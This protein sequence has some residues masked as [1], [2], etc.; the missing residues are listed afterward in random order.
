[1]VGHG[2]YNPALLHAID[3][4]MR[5]FEKDRPQ[6]VGALRD[7]VVR[8]IEAPARPASRSPQPQRPPAERAPQRATVQEAFSNAPTERSVRPRNPA[9]TTA[10]LG[11]FMVV[12]AGAGF[13]VGTRNTGASSFDAARATEPPRPSREPIGKRS[14]R[15]PKDPVTRRLSCHWSVT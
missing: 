1:M 2:R 3:M 13:Y 5:V 4:A 11:V 14:Q 7:L 6:T 15:T 12:I 10:L 8:G 9:L